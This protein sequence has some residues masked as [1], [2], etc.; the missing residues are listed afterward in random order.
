MNNSTPNT[1]ITSVDNL[2][3]KNFVSSYRT[4]L[5]PA[6]LELNTYLALTNYAN[7]IDNVIDIKFAGL[8]SIP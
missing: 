3:V 4:F 2:A 8:T 7:K 5:N 1:S 6:A